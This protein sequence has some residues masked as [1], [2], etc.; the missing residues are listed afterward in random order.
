MADAP[1]YTAGRN[2]GEARLEALLPLLACPLCLSPVARSPSAPDRF[3]ECPSCKRRYSIRGGRPLL[4]SGPDEAVM[5][6]FP[7]SEAACDYP[8]RILRYLEEHPRGWVLD[9]GSGFNVSRSFDRV[10]RLDI[11]AFPTVD[12]IGTGECLPFPDETFDGVISL[13]MLEHVT[14]PFLAAR[15]MARVLKPGGA[16]M[17]DAPFLAPVHRFPHHYFNVTR[18]GLELLFRDFE[19][20]SCVVEPYQHAIF[21]LRWIL[22]AL[23]Q[24]AADEP[25]REAIRRA[26][27][28]EALHVLT[29]PG[30][31]APF[32]RLRPEAAEVLACGF[33]YNG[34]KPLRPAGP[35]R[36]PGQGRARALET[37]GLE[38]QF[39]LLERTTWASQNRIQGLGAALRELSAAAVAGDPVAGYLD[40]PAEGKP[41]PE[42]APIRGWA[43]SPFGIDRVEVALD[44]GPPR[45]AC[46]GHFRPDVKTVFPGRAGAE[47]SGWVLEEPLRLPP[48]PHRIAARAVDFAGRELV[49]AD[50]AFEAGASRACGWW[51][52]PAGKGFDAETASSDPEPD[53]VARYVRGEGIEIG[54]LHKP[55][56]APPNAKV[57]RVDRLD[58]E[59]LLRHY[60]EIEPHLIGEPDVR[61]EAAD[62]SPFGDRSLD[63]VIGR[64]VLEHLP[65]PIGALAEWWRVL[66]PGGAVYLI[67]PDRRFIF[68][69]HRPPTSLFHLVEN[70]AARAREIEPEH[71]REWVT[72]VENVHGEEARARRAEELRA[73]QYSIHAHV[74]EAPQIAGLVEWSRKNLGTPWAVEVFLLYGGGLYLVIRKP[75][76]RPI[77][78]GAAAGRPGGP[79]AGGRP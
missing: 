7:A 48:G 62:L 57:L 1:Q 50:R 17:V 69:Q 78:A 71:Y 60:P 37:V 42:G 24:G 46:L 18:R 53:I 51:D 33:S 2:A 14:D 65:D 47:T 58:R 5:P 73:R 22:E 79:A 10:V 63:F 38:R 68:D 35:L 70:F 27:I 52:G 9:C 74:F 8:P 45:T 66:R 54:A 15:E 55:I 64:H 25:A 56:G 41:L 21:T 29:G 72:L 34:R 44:G 61:A 4:L 30:D 13:A 43:H 26:T 19:T 76:E 49:L 11:F 31:K 77:P 3:L 32:T 59:G 75:A 40:E 28:E 12:V 16:V 20:E 39:Y 23:L 36:P 6:A 67:V